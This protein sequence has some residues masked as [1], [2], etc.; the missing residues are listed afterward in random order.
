MRTLKKYIIGTA[1]LSLGLT[2][3]SDDQVLDLN[4]ISSIPESVAFTTPEYVLASV[5]GMYQAAQIGYYNGAGARGYM[6][7]AAYIQQN[8][9]RGEDVV[10]TQGFYAITYENSQDPN[11]AANTIYYWVD[12]YRLINR[13]N[14]VIEGVQ[15]AADNGVITQA[16]AD[17]YAGQAKF[18]RAITHFELL[19]FFANP[20]GATNGETPGIPYRDFAINTSA[21]IEQGMAED[22][23]TVKQNYI[24]I[25]ADLDAAEATIT[26]N[27]LVK[28]SKNAAIGY[29]AKVKL[30]MRDWAGVLTEVAKIENAYTLTPEPWGVFDNNA[31]NT[32]SI[33]SILNTAAVNPGV[34]GAIASQYKRRQL[35]AISPI[36]WNDTDWTADDKRRISTNDADD[37]VDNL[38][39]E[40]T[41]ELYVT[42]KYR[43][44]VTYTDYTPILRHADIL[45]MKAEAEARNSNSITAAAVDALNAVRDRALVSSPSYT[46]ADFTS[47]GDF[48]AKVIKERRIEFVMEGK[49]WADIHRLQQDPLAEVS[50][51]GIPAKFKSGSNPKMSSYTIG[52]PPA[53]AN[54]TIAPIPYSDYRFLWPIPSLETVYNPNVPQNPGY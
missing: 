28:A 51:N 8:D 32:E 46:A 4:P 48:V 12:G 41:G 31:T 34:N 50:M 40:L 27:S 2:S 26:E 24:K 33:F 23:S 36:L 9:F 14:I 38:V 54:L 53:A 39:Y 18:L 25:L 45:L 22:R 44:G 6:W 20:Y 11:A 15:Q 52:T 47:V 19:M 3:C 10:N 29:K 37:N 21:S 30:H 7:G 17:N 42:N 1:L 35:G 16:Q 43:D 13:C 49:R 5:N